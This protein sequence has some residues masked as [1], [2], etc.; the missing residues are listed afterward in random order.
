VIKQRGSNGRAVRSAA[1]AEQDKRAWEL[2]TRSLTYSQ[3]GGILG[4]AAS[5][6][7]ESATCGAALVPTEGM[8]ELK[9]AELAKLDRIECH[10]RDAMTREHVRVDHGRVIT[11]KRKPVIDDAPV[12]QAAVA[13]LR[14]QERRAKLLRLDEPAKHR[15][16]VIT[17]EVVDA[18]IK[19]LEQ[20]LGLNDRSAERRSA[21]T[22]R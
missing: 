21:P 14:V 15:V 10:L 12:I 11:Y 2:R 9:R 20:E 3:I 5:T 17:E 18:E 6:A 1:T 16:D 7:Y 8:I 19:R 22:G 4:I 13:L